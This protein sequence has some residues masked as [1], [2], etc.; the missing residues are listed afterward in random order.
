MELD[1]MTTGNF[2]FRWGSDL[3]SRLSAAV[4]SEVGRLRASPS[5]IPVVPGSSRYEDVVQDLRISVGPPYS[6]KPGARLAPIKLALDFTLA[7]QQFADE[8]LASRLALRPASD[9]AFAE[10]AILLHGANAAK[11]LKDLH[12]KDENG[13]LDQQRGLFAS[14]PKPLRADKSIMDSIREG[15]EQLQKNHQ[16][17]PYCVVLAPDLH[18]EAITP[19]GTSST[20]RIAPILPQ[21]REQAFRFSEAAAPRTGVV[22]SLGGGA[23]DIMVQWDAHVECRK[24]EGDAT[25]VVAEQ[26]CLRIN[27]ERAVVTLS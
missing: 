3:A 6:V 24:I 21:L 9:L 4:K 5:V 20:P 26:F 10:D 19:Q 1:A 22:F 14:P 16:H 12:V 11:I 8:V 25:F 15:L 7:Q 17:G 23:I 27:D 18:R 2:D 13:T